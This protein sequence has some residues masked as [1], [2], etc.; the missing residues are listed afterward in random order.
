MIKKIWQSYLLINYCGQRV[1]GTFFNKNLIVNTIMFELSFVLFFI[2]LTIIAE[3]GIKNIYLASIICFSYV[4]ILW[5]YGE[6]KVSNLIDYN[7]LEVQYKSMN[8]HARILCLP[9][10]ILILI[11][12]V[13]FM[14][15]M[16]VLVF[17]I[18]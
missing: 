8:K 11:F 16:I 3:I 5:W 6:K 12:S 7:G 2:P 17:K 15:F 4:M 14:L 13:I 10:A 1:S 9:I 18:I